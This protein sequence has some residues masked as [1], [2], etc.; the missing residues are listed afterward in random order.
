M[1]VCYVCVIFLSLWIV[2]LKTRERALFNWFKENRSNFYIKTSHLISL[3]VQWLRF[4]APRSGGLGSVPGLDPTYA[5]KDPA[6][7]N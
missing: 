6:C 2:F 7:H 1:Y 3:L 4:Y 5:N